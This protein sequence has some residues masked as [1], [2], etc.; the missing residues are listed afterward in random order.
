[1]EVD[2][3]W[4]RYDTQLQGEVRRLRIHQSEWALRYSLAAGFMASQLISVFFWNN[5]STTIYRS[6]I[7]SNTLQAY[8]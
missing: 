6:T 3:E 2:P 4:K 8:R 1:M 5:F 7:P